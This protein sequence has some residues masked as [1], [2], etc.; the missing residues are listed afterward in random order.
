M[1][2]MI[3]LLAFFSFSFIAMEYLGHDMAGHAEI[4]AEANRVLGRPPRAR[5][6]PIF[7][8][9]LDPTLSVG[10]AEF[11]SHFRYVLLC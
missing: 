9:R 7:N 6:P 11:K 8:R 10:D 5:N 1:C 2:F 4:V 3:S